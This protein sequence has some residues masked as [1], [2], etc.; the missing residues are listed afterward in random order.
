ML[1]ELNSALPAKVWLTDFSEKAG[2]VSLSG[3]GDTEKTVA[4][5]MDRLERSPY[6][7]NIELSVTEQSSVGEVKMQK[8][9]LKCQTEKPSAK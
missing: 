6:Y 7:R 3:F 8:F 5:F 1:D 2:S 4:S 9:T